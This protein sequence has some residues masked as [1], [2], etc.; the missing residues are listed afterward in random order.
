VAGTNSLARTTTLVVNGALTDTGSLTVASSITG[1]GSVSISAN[2]VLSVGGKAGMHGLTFLPGGHETVA[3]GTPSAVSA[4]IATFIKT[5]TIDLVDFVAT[6]LAASRH[7]LTVDGTGGA[8]AHLMFAA[9]H[10][11]SN[12]ALAP[13]GHGGTNITHT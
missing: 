5:D 12:F 10:T 3:F 1:T 13:D 7:T 6:K 2:S 4:S 9:N 8:V 11:T